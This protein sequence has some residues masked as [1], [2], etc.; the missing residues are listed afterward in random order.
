MTNDV[1][2]TTKDNLI[3]VIDE[4]EKSIIIRGKLAENIQ[5]KQKLRKAFLIALVVFSVSL[6]VYPC[7][8]VLLHPRTLSVSTFSRENNNE[9]NEVSTIDQITQY[10]KK[11][12]FSFNLGLGLIVIISIFSLLRSIINKYDEILFKVDGKVEI[13]LVHK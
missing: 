7:I 12:I 10:T 11:E 2:V 1:V 3:K 8:N 4:D 9:N 13:H 5:R 6:L